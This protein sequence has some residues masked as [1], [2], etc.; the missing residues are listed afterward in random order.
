MTFI[1]T[2]ANW[3]KYPFR[4]FISRQ[5]S[6]RRYWMRHTRY[7]H[8]KHS[9]FSTLLCLSTLC[10][11]AL[12]ADPAAMESVYVDITPARCA[13]RS[14]NDTHSASVQLCPGI[15]GYD[16][17]VDDFDGRQ[18]VSIVKP[19]KAI[20]P[21]AIERTIS[22]GFFTLGTK[23]EWR[24]RRDGGKAIP[25][26]LIIRIIASESPD[27]PSRKTHYLA[28]TK[29]TPDEV[30]VTDRISAGATMNEKAR[31]AADNSSDRPCL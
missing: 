1:P 7:K 25:R 11:M 29:I 26:A 2:L 18:S 30:C 6:L 15:A 13:T 9:G 10:G 24:T 20:Q 17:R 8:M 12:A 31:Q 5:D 19:N 21:L 14:L 23:A 16:L 3:Q 28:V 4:A 27:S 22:T